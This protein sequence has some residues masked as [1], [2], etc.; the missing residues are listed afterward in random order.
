MNSSE[1]MMHSASGSLS[2]ASRAASALRGIPLTSHLQHSAHIAHAPLCSCTKQ[3]FPRNV[4]QATRHTRRD[5]PN[6]LQMERGLGR[7]H[8]RRGIQ[9]EIP[10]LRFIDNVLG[11]ICRRCAGKQSAAGLLGGAG[12]VILAMNA[13]SHATTMSLHWLG[14]TDNTRLRRCHK[15]STRHNTH[16]VPYMHQPQQ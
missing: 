6:V 4:R 15:C 10:D 3:Q 9:Q 13:L 16:R 2:F 8:S 5:P 12:P 11:S 7:W 1:E 14:S